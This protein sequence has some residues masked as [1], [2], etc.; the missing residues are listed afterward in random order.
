MF[1]RV[2]YI[3]PSKPDT[4]ILDLVD[5]GQA[6]IQN[7]LPFGAAQGIAIDPATGALSRGTDPRRGGQF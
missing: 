6:M 4:P 7:T 5:R 1:D 3:S 2:E